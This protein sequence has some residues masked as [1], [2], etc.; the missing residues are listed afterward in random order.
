MARE[1][2]RKK[3]TFSS[4]TSAGMMSEGTCV[5]L[6][7]IISA[8]EFRMLTRALKIRPLISNPSIIKIVKTKGLGDP[9][10]G[11][12]GVNGPAPE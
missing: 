2:R 11:D 10:F 3:C 12:N 8:H 1:T 5:L 6:H 4:N 9:K 7:I